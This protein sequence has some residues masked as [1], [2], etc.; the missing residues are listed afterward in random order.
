VKK[1]IDHEFV[2]DLSGG[3]YFLYS[4]EVSFFKDFDGF[5]NNKKE[6]VVFLKKYIMK[7]NNLTSGFGKKQ[8][9]LY[10]SFYINKGE[11]ALL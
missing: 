3:I 5:V 6:K 4:G 8:V 10:L 1:L 7:I 2:E 11:L 9:L